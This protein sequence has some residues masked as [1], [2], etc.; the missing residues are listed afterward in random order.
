MGAAV[1]AATPRPR[2]L[3]HA[4]ENSEPGDPAI[5][6]VEKQGWDHIWLEWEDVEDASSKP[7]KSPSR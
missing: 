4:Q 6:V 1:T 3:Q 7:T 2:C 5:T